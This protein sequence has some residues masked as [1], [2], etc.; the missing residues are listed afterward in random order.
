MKWVTFYI[1]IYSFTLSVN[2]SV[3]EAMDEW[4]F[5]WWDTIPVR[6]YILFTIVFTGYVCPIR[7]SSEII[8]SK[9]FLTFSLFSWERILEHLGAILEH[10]L[11][12]MLVY[13]S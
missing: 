5:V 13:G 7:K 4:V 9:F 12:I 6:L 3:Y 2:S 10:H 11:T 8:L 1:Y